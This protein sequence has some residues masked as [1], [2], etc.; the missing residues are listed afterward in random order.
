MGLKSSER[1]RPWLV[2][3][4]NERFQRRLQSKNKLG[5][6]DVFALAEQFSKRILPAIK[7]CFYASYGLPIAGGPLN[8]GFNADI[9]LPRDFA[10]RLE[11]IG[12]ISLP[13]IA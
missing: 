1:G 5:A 9:R 7:P 2:P 12:E 3:V 4:H 13:V 8:A 10:A 11:V 6:Y